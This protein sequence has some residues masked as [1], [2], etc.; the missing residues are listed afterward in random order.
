MAPPPP[1]PLM[2][3][4]LT[5]NVAKPDQQQT[6]SEYYRTSKDRSEAVQVQYEAEL[7]KWSQRWMLGLTAP[8]AQPT[9]RVSVSQQDESKRAQVSGSSVRSGPPYVY[10][11]TFHSTP[12]T[13]GSKQ[14]HAQPKDHRFQLATRSTTRSSNPQTT[15]QP[16]HLQNEYGVKRGAIRV[17]LQRH[18]EQH[19]EG[20]EGSGQ[21]RNTQSTPPILA[22]SEGEQRARGNRSLPRRRQSQHPTSTRQFMLPQLTSVPLDLE[23]DGLDDTQ[24]L[25]PGE[26]ETLRPPS[27]SWSCS[28]RNGDLKDGP[29]QNDK[30]SGTAATHDPDE[31]ESAQGHEDEVERLKAK[32]KHQ[33]ERYR[34]EQQKA[35]ES[36]AKEKRQR[37]KLEWEVRDREKLEEEGREKDS[38]IA[39]LQAQKAAL[40]QQMRNEGE[41]QEE[42]RADMERRFEVK[43]VGESIRIER[44]QQ[45][46]G[47][48]ERVMYVAGINK[49]KESWAALDKERKE[50]RETLER[51]R[52]E[53]KMELEGE[54]KG[55][56]QLEQQ[57]LALKRLEIEYRKDQ[58]KLERE[59]LEREKLEV[60]LAKEME[61]RER[62][63]LERQHLE[64][65]VAQL[66]SQVSG[67]LSTQRA[68][69]EGA[70]RSH[71]QRPPS[72]FSL[73]QTNGGLRTSVFSYQSSIA[74]STG[75]IPRL[76]LSPHLSPVGLNQ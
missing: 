23:N 55:R 59:R 5:K 74:T 4:P 37:M 16:L 68:P 45:E 34:E 64:A 32:L 24:R 61:Q 8:E 1:P 31:E 66:S 9:G 67:G 49:G 65:L 43:L 60:E 69:N 33:E 12:K 6:S 25:E 70:H 41:K 75:P 44:E 46:K 22:E 30:S 2:P 14:S 10:H 62:L 38:L 19:K 71:I 15:T 36:L 52:E 48:L 7:A 29:N 76:S 47:R 3:F 73:A 42:E 72:E 53:L 18:R 13:G 56:R 54:R 58:G 21:P 35:M 11:T 57:R 40:E 27:S 39:K 26:Q 63:E 20:N 17:D 50:E 51:Q 28:S